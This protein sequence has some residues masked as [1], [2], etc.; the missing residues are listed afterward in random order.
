[1]KEGY[2]EKSLSPSGED[3]E[4]INAFTVSP[5]DE[6]ELYIFSVVLC[7][8]DIDRDNEKFSVEALKQLAKLFTGKTGIC[9]HSMR[10]AD[11][12]ARIF[13]AFVEK[14][15]GRKTVDGEDYYQLKAKAYMVRS[16]EN[17][18]LITE[19][20]AGIKKEVSVSC[21]AAKC[22]CSVCGKDKHG[23]KCGHI[24]GRVY[25]GKPA[26]SI[27]S[28]IKDAYEFSFVAVPAQREAGVTKAFAS[29]KETV[30]TEEIIG[31][32]KSCRQETVMSQAQCEALADYIDSL[33]ADAQLGRE[34]RKSLANEV[35]RLC[36]TAMPDMDIKAFGSVAQV[37]THNELLCFK[38]A[39]EKSQGSNH[40]SVQIKSDTDKKHFNEFRI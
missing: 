1:L 37:M 22:T 21:A 9:D 17:L 14:V 31:T 38:K 32:L 27:L 19:I 5:F 3:I 34:Y 40:G 4:K 20:E 6:E 30:E 29:K 13:D 39:F 7:N 11:Q 25:D 36:A 33:E 15:E 23:G 26:F 35:V 12:K 16:E 2:V 28:D 18:P 8:N 24:G 10:S